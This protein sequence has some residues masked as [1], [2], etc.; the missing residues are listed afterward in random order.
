HRPPQGMAFAVAGQKHLIQV[1]RV[2]RTG[3]PPLELMGVLLAKLQTS[4]SDGLM[5]HHDTTGQQHLFPIAVTQA[6]AVREP[7]PMTENFAGK[8]VVLGAF[9]VRGWSHVGCLLWGS[10]G[11]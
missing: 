2:A 3:T 10:L 8:A 4:L 9:G 7:N 11:P 5:H 1:P 6:E